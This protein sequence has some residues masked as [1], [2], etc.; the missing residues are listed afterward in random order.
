MPPKRSK[1]AKSGGRKPTK[2]GGKQLL[3]ETSSDRVL[4]KDPKKKKFPEDEGE[5]PQTVRK[6]KPKGRP[7]KHTV[8]E[9]KEDTVEIMARESE[10]DFS[11][12]IDSGEAMENSSS[13]ATPLN[14]EK[15]SPEKDSDHDTGVV[16]DSGMAERIDMHVGAALSKYFKKRR[17]H[18]KGKKKRKKR[19]SVESSS[20]SDESSEMSSSDSES[21]T[22]SVSS[23]SSDERRRAKKRKR[24]EKKKQHQKA[25]KSKKGK[26]NLSEANQSTSVSTVYTR[27]C[28]SPQ[29][30]IMETGSDVSLDGGGI[31]SDAD[32]DEFIAS[33]NTSRDH[34]TPDL[35]RNGDR[36]DGGGRKDESREDR[37]RRADVDD[38]RELINDRY[39][40]QAD[41]VVRDLHINKAEL[42]KPS[43]EVSDFS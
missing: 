14:N 19:E 6:G 8:S 15:E 4:R 27:G 38:E 18:K 3:T 40:E 11:D 23:Y 2:N 39:R 12:D 10:D 1:T 20:D 34:S 42:A 29:N 37:R 30:A 22:S 13:N 25:K 33:L 43:G 32:T 31:D 16:M 24:K 26:D 41:A 36:R 5:N 28:K 17:S 35:A 7:K 9:N 21:E